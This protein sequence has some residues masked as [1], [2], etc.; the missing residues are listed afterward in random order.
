[1][2][3]SRNGGLLKFKMAAQ[4]LSFGALHFWKSVLYFKRHTLIVTRENRHTLIVPLVTATMI[5]RA[6]NKVSFKE[7]FG[8]WAYREMGGGV[9]IRGCQRKMTKRDKSVKFLVS[10]V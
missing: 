7:M 6:L 10:V 3:I 5:V 2:G 4:N 9:K 1:M 8:K